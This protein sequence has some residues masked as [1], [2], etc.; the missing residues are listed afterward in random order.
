MESEILRALADPTRRAVFEKL[1]AGEMTVGAL[2]Q[3][4]AVSQPTLRLRPK[5]MPTSLKYGR[6][7]SPRIARPLR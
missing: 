3:N 4:F 1:A 6:G 2:K 5:G 7:I